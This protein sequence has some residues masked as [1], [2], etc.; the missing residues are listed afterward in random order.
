[1]A[2]GFAFRDD[3]GNEIARDKERDHRN[4]RQHKT[5]DTAGP[6]WLFGWGLCAGLL[7]LLGLL[8]LLLLLLLLC[9][10]LDIVQTRDERQDENGNNDVIDGARFHR[11]C[12]KMAV[13][14]VLYTID[15]NVGG[16]IGAVG[17]GWEWV[18][19]GLCWGEKKMI[20]ICGLMLGRLPTSVVKVDSG[21]MAPFENL[22]KTLFI[23]ALMVFRH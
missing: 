20:F 13:L 5:T 19:D 7:G 12:V 10:V 11:K 4:G 17:G 2:S 8:L 1:M 6:R 21:K 15:N 16:G 18:W 14:D 23:W 9:H 22:V 3:D